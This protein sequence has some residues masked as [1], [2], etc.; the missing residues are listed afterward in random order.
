MILVVETSLVVI[1]DC[2]RWRRGK[3]AAP[4]DGVF[5]VAGV[6]EGYEHWRSRCQVSRWIYRR[7]DTGGWSVKH[8]RETSNSV[9]H[10]IQRRAKYPLL[11]NTQMS[12]STP[13]YISPWVWLAG[14]HKSHKPFLNNSPK[15]SVRE[16]QSRLGESAT[17]GSKHECRLESLCVRQQTIWQMSWRAGAAYKREREAQ[18][19]PIMQRLLTKLGLLRVWQEVDCKNKRGTRSKVADCYKEFPLCS[20][21]GEPVSC[22]QPDLTNKGL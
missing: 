3:M 11:G 17:A 2:L 4:S 15:D 22:S 7:R 20:C 6:E 14:S 5:H 19:K 8:N 12:T 10:Q 9:Q 13:Q 21:L 18:V 1:C 16:G